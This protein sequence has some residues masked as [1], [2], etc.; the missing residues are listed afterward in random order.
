VETAPLGDIAHRPCCSICDGP[1][2]GL[3]ED[4]LDYLWAVTAVDDVTEDLKSR[5]RQTRGFDEPDTL[6]AWQEQRQGEIDACRRASTIVAALASTEP[7]ISQL[8]DD[9]ATRIRYRIATIETRLSAGPDSG[10][11][12]PGHIVAAGPSAVQAWRATKFGKPRGQEAAVTLPEPHEADGADAPAQR[13]TSRV[14][15][16]PRSRARVRTPGYVTGITHQRAEFA[17]TISTAGR[18]R[19][20]PALAHPVWGAS[21][22]W[23]AAK[24]IEKHPAS[25]GRAL[26]WGTVTSS[27]AHQACDSSCGDGLPICD[28]FHP[29]PGMHPCSS[30]CPKSGCCCLTGE[31][32]TCS[33]SE[34]TFQST[35][36][37]RTHSASCSPTDSG[38]TSRRRPTGLPDLLEQAR[39]SWIRC[40]RVEHDHFNLPTAGTQFVVS[41][42]R[43]SD[44]IDIVEGPPL[45]DAHRWWDRH[46]ADQPEE[47]DRRERSTATLDDR[48]HA[49]P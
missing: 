3:S 29:Y 37:T 33:S 28:L 43:A 10:E 41:E 39:Q 17:R 20:D 13:P 21:Y 22:E 4:H 45:E 38:P 42:L 47:A 24:L 40:L 16:T 18:C 11:L 12:P 34:D 7:R 19:S 44:V 31:D 9:I 23:M 32:G 25:A 46:L 27:I 2:F 36:T 1:G 48:R 35:K 26:I 6:M 5:L 15:D 49:A 8:A 14:I 30:R